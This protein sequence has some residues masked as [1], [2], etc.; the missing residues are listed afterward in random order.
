G[1]LVQA[2]AL[3]FVLIAAAVGW[4]YKTG[5][6]DRARAMAVKEILF[7]RPEA[8]PE[9]AADLSAAAATTQPFLRLDAL[10]EKHAG[11]RA[12]DQVEVI[13]QTFDVQSAVLDRP[14]PDL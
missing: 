5:R 9:P 2:L 11:K 13:Q 3:N 14:T 10:L 1:I 12:G 7:P 6:L 8:P 4:L